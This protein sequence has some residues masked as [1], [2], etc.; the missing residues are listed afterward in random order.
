MTIADKGYKMKAFELRDQNGEKVS[1]KD[2]KGKIL[3]AF[4]PLAFTSVCNDQM[5]DLENEYDE[6]TKRG[7][8]PLGISVD[9]HPSKG[10]WADTL[11]LEKLTILSDFNPKGEVAKDLGVYIEKAGISGRAVVLVDEDGTVLWSKEY[12][13]SQRPDVNEILEAID[14][15]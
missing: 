12:E 1:S 9:A 11:A 4:H 15:L 6:F 8:T 3:L 10:V 7:I 14:N 5:R 13:K 2:I